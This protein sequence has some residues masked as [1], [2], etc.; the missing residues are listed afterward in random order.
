MKNYIIVGIVVLIVVFFL[1]KTKKKENPQS[2][3]DMAKDDVNINKPGLL[4]TDQQIVEALKSIADEYG[5]DTARTV[6]KMYRLET[7]HFKSGQYKNT[8]SPGMEKHDREYPFGWDSMKS[9]WD[10]INFVPEFHTMPENK[11][12]K[13]KTFLK[14]PNVL[15]PM[16]SLAIYVKKYAPER[17]YSKNPVKQAEY[18]NSLNSI[19]PRIVNTFTA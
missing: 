2:I 12:G 9:Y 18:R 19:K 13:T 5:I 7:N 11:T 3:R 16:R 14:F 17:W 4:T 8:F 15:I 6:E 1:W 10:S